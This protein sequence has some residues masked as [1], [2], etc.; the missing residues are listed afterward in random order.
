VVD[1]LI[2]L[3][4]FAVRGHRDN[5]EQYTVL[6][7][8]KPAAARQVLIDVTRFDAE[9]IA[10]I[11]H[12]VRTAQPQPVDLMA[13]LIRELGGEL[14]EVRLAPS[15]SRTGVRAT[16]IL[17]RTD[18]QWVEVPARASD[19]IALATLNGVAILMHAADVEEGHLSRAAVPLDQLYFGQGSGG[20]ADILAS[21]APGRGQPPTFPTRLQRPLAITN[22]T[23]IPMD[24]PHPRPVQTVV[25]E[26]GT[27]VQV[28]P[29]AEICT[30]NLQV[31]DGAGKFMMPGLADVHVQSLGSRGVLV[32][33]AAHAALPRLPAARLQAQR[34]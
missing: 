26:N 21:W 15:P 13:S 4:L 22:V 17:G 3:E 16:L 30:D 34:P 23:V 7:R 20:P 29:S 31:L 32:E 10:G 18:G 6:L 12:A 28:A 9:R 11:L 1:D 19:A 24:A 14:R 2:E 5:P 27:I 25:I 8:E 33:W